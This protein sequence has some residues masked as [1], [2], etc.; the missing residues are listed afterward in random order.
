MHQHSIKKAR[1][2]TNDIY[3]YIKI[4]LFLKGKEEFTVTELREDSTSGGSIQNYITNMQKIG[5]IEKTDKKRA[6]GSVIYR[7]VDPKVRYANSEGIDIC[8]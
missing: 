1:R 8:H 5:L 2:N 3:S 4:L 6:G 7:I